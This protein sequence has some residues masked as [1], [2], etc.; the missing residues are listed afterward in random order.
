[1]PETLRITGLTKRFGTV[2]AVD[3]FT[4][5][6]PSGQF[7]GVIGPSGAGKSTLLRLINRLV[8]PDSGTIRH[9]AIDVTALHGKPLRHWRARAAMIFQQFNLIPRL[10]VLTNVL[11]GR[12]E[13]RPALPSLFGLFRASDRADALLALDRFGLADVA[14]QRAGTLSGGQQ[15]RVAICRAL[16]QN[17]WLMLADEPI[18]SLDPHN[19]RLVMQ[20]LRQVN[21]DHGLTVLANLHHLDEVRTY[22]DRVIAMRAGRIVLDG[23]PA[24]LT[25]DRVFDIYG[26]TEEELEAVDH[27]SGANQS[28]GIKRRRSMTLLAG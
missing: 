28:C 17:P 27:A 13:Q 8:E 10:D 21:R 7:V 9:G 18:A 11:V 1:M 22:C 2:T 4:A 15:Q 23:T 25:P 3:G 6:I 12:L 19:A 24:D 5:D 20:A 26:V 14:L 16:L